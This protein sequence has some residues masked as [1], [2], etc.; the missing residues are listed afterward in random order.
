MKTLILLVAI[1]VGSLTAPTAHA[2]DTTSPKSFKGYIVH[3]VVDGHN[4][5][6]AYSKKGKW[7]YTIKQY[8]TDNLDSSVVERVKPVFYDYNVTGIEKVEQPGKDVVYV[9]HLENAK[10][11][12]LVRLTNDEM[13]IVQDFNKG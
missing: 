5:I 7:I 11:I 12:K 9:V 2:S 1:V 4:A 13:E 10:S 6:S 8:R 3:S